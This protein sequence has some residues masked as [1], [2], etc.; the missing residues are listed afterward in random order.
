MRASAERPPLPRPALPTGGAGS[1]LASPSG[2]LAPG[3]VWRGLLAAWSSCR[4]T[5]LAWALLGGLLVGTVDLSALQDL[6]AEQQRLSVVA[7][8]LLVPMGCAAI[9]LLAWLPADR[10]PA[11]ALRRPAWLLLAVVLGA[12]CATAL[13]TWL[14]HLVPWPHIGELVRRHKGLPVPPWHW[15]EGLADVLSL[16]LF[17]GL[18][19]ALVELM[20]RRRRMEASTAAL[21]RQHDQRQRQALSAR[22]SAVQARLEPDLLFRLLVDI[23]RRFAQD[24]TQAGAQLERLIQHLRLALPTL[25]NPQVSLACEQALLASWLGLMGGLHHASWQLQADLSPEMSQRQLPGMLLLPLL[26]AAC[27]ELPDG[28]ALRVQLAASPPVSEITARPAPLSPHG[29][30]LVLSLHG[31]G[32]GGAPAGAHERLRLLAGEAARL[33]VLVEPGRTRFTLDLPA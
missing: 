16:T 14:L 20:R 15:T 6:P 9:L 32:L 4:W 2:D 26:Q 13:L 33:Q 8:H 24:D 7:R 29:L 30:H 27:A 17:G 21:L 18:A 10:R 12:F 19:V 25:Q 11:E 28:Q 31:Q 23:E 1:T 3:A 22:L 5:E